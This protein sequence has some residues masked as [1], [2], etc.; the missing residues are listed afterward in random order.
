MGDKHRMGKIIELLKRKIFHIDGTDFGARKKI[1]IRKAKEKK[2][3]IL[4][5]LGIF[6]FVV[7]L[8]GGFYQSTLSLFGQ[9]DHVSLSPFVMLSYAFRLFPVTFII[10]AVVGGCAVF[11]IISRMPKA[12]WNEEQ[13]VNYKPDDGTYG[14][15][16]MMTEDD[17]NLQKCMNI[18]DI[19]DDISSGIIIGATSNGEV[20]TFKEDEEGKRSTLPNHHMCITGPSGCGKSRCVAFNLIF[21]SI[22]R[23]E[24]FVVSETSGELYGN[25]SELARK[26]GY[27]VRLLDYR[28]HMVSHSDSLNVILQVVKGSP[29]NAMKLATILCDSANPKKDFWYVTQ[30]SCLTACILVVDSQPIPR[31]EK[32]LAKIYDLCCWSSDEL[33]VMFKQLDPRHPAYSHGRKFAN[34]DKKVKDGAIG[35]LQAMLQVYADESIKHISSYDEVDLLLPGKE[36]CAYYVEISDNQNT[37]SFMSSVFFNFLFTGL[38]EMATLNRGLKLKVPVNIMLDEFVSIGIISDFVKKLANVRKY[39]IQIIVLFQDIPQ[40]IETYGGES[41]KAWMS[42]MSNCSINICLG[43]N[44]P[45]TTAEYYSKYTGIGTVEA[46]QKRLGRNAFMPNAPKIEYQET[47]SLASRALQNPDEIMKLQP[48]EE[49]VFIQYHGPVKLKKFDYSKHYMYR[50]ISPVMTTDHVPEWWRHHPEYYG[51]SNHDPVD[52]ER[53]IPK[54]EKERPAVENRM[55]GLHGQ[56]GNPTSKD[57]DG[58]AISQRLGKGRESRSGK[59]GSDKK[60][61]F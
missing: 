40:L 3:H 60:L 38:I 43:C 29:I 56:N 53:K 58:K 1:I 5:V 6:F 28:P 2:I 54:P 9:I 42:I 32:S 52:F 26:N 47:N 4:V 37:L 22:R 7:Y 24:S 12:G 8:V 17:P 25:T 48:E 39:S 19:E 49:I 61:N 51:D 41:G 23:G 34:A 50:E 27:T 31:H 33:T 46:Q 20:L 18:G 45:I 10:W 21:Q 11:F 13:N 55:L 59:V 57:E 14:T 16:I 30:L 35:G 36:K 15:A 44:E